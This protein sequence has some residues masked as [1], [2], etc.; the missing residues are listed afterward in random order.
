MTTAV[1]LALAI[2][3]AESGSMSRLE[4]YAQEA[5]NNIIH[6]AYEIGYRDGENS[7]DADQLIQ[8]ELDND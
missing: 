2:R 8:E 5:I 4:A 3:V 6:V 7:A 1:E